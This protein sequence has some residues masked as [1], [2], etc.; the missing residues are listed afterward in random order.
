MEP[1]NNP[2][3][4]LDARTLKQFSKKII[5]QML[6]SWI[7]R[8][9]AIWRNPNRLLSADRFDIPAKIIYARNFLRGT[10]DGWPTDLYLAH[11][12]SFNSF[13]EKDPPKNTE[14][15]FLNTF[16]SLLESTALRG[17]SKEIS[18]VPIDWRDL[19]F[20]INGAHR[21]AAGIS[22]SKKI[23]CRLVDL[24]RRHRWDYSY[25]LNRGLKECYADAIALEFVDV[26]RATRAF[27]VYQHL[28][29]WKDETEA[30][31]AASGRIVYRKRVSIEENARTEFTRLLYSDEKWVGNH[32]NRF[33]G[34][35]QKAGECFKKGG[36]VTLYLV[37][38]NDRKSLLAGKNKLREL[39]QVGKH[40]VHSTDSWIETVGISET[41][42]N[43]NSLSS[44]GLR[45]YR[46]CFRFETFIK[47]FKRSA[48]TDGI[49]LADVCLSGSTVLAAFGL[50]DCNDIDYV[51]TSNTPEKFGQNQ[52]HK[53]TSEVKYY[54]HSFEQIVSDPRF[55]FRYR[56]LKICTPEVVARMKYRR[57]E[58]KDLVDL[59]LLR[60]VGA[61]GACK[62]G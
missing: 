51:G 46:P 11:I 1:T 39:S 13:F 5:R 6:N 26:C 17:V 38:P 10:Q 15:D 57:S 19:N 34:A 61:E 59:D 54:A 43:Q 18:T 53:H 50:R 31:I 9:P 7:N 35:R 60:S 58:P 21:I 33:S 47:S 48:K 29:Q 40:S 37:I 8:L 12:S 52:F 27:V 55:H 30:A 36:D 4:F 45:Q 23:P 41:L 3:I 24:K 56:G 49:N 22:L 42:L 16:N 62:T 44:L 20:P 32:E 14:A 28:D 25:F 2:S